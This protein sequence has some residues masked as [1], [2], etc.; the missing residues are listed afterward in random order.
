MHKNPSSTGTCCGFLPLTL[1]CSVGWWVWF[2][3][4]LTQT[5]TPLQLSLIHADIPNPP[6]QKAAPD[7]TTS[8][9]EERVN[10]RCQWL[11]QKS[12]H[13][14]Y[15]VVFIRTTWLFMKMTLMLLAICGWENKGCIFIENMLHFNCRELCWATNDGKQ[16]SKFTQ[17]LALYFSFVLISKSTLLPHWLCRL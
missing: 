14:T 12:M 3:R 11:A 7:P 9:S 8:E 5:W 15:T 4:V 16:L 6:A 17:V 2:G 1:L 13:L 10:E